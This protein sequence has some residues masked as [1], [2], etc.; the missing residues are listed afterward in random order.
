MEKTLKKYPLGNEAGSDRD[1]FDDDTTFYDREGVPGLIVTVYNEA[2]QR[3]AESARLAIASGCRES[4]DK[5]RWEEAVAQ[6]L[7]LVLGL[8]PGDA[9][10]QKFEG[11]DEIELP[12]APSNSAD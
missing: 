5:A 2:A 1:A 7:E 11:C 12:E 6:T 10:G 4:L 3:A 8:F 9:D